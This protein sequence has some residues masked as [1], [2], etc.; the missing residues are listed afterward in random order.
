[1][2]PEK[3]IK[4]EEPDEGGVDDLL[5]TYH[6]DGERLN[7]EETQTTTPEK[8]QQNQWMPSAKGRSIVWEHIQWTSESQRAACNYCQA[9]FQIKGGTSALLRHL[10]TNHPAAINFD[11]DNPPPVARRRKRKT[12]EDYT[13]ITEDTTS[14]MDNLLQMFST[15]DDIAK[16]DPKAPTSPQP[17]PLD[18]HPLHAEQPQSRADSEID[19]VIRNLQNETAQNGGHVEP[20]TDENLRKLLG[21]VDG[22][23]GAPDGALEDSGA[24][25]KGAEPPRLDEE[26][27]ATPTVQKPQKTTTKKLAIDDLPPPMMM[28]MRPPPM[29][30]LNGGKFPTSILSALHRRPPPP[31]MAFLPP[32]PPPPFPTVPPTAVQYPNGG[33]MMP[34][35]YNSQAV[36]CLDFEA[37]VLYN[38]SMHSTIARED[39][40]TTYYRMKSR[41]MELEIK[42][43]EREL[44]EEHDEHEH[45]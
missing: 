42:K 35:K 43:L 11:P 23:G 17:P 10:K 41:K 22:V 12:M 40:M 29:E 32:P 30:G 28:M 21:M 16:I 36:Q 7:L 9:E 33:G 34:P 4:V 26:K 27:Q 19:E 1:M 14:Y 44:G 37:K 13:V 15:P 25:E 38:Q 6:E 39:A 5:Q 2:T 8:Q 20:P 18:F 24:V 31:Q 45:E 3:R